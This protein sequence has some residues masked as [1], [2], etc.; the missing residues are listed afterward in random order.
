MDTTMNIRFDKL[1]FVKK[2][3]EANQPPEVAEAFADALDDALDQSQRNLMTKTDFELR[4]TQL[5]AKF[6]TKLS[7][8]EARL[9]D[10][11]NTM[12][13]K[14]VGLMMAGIGFLMTII[15]FIN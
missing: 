9:T 15:K 8:M 14:M 10:T 3:Q 13:Y 5:E 1:R 7:Q 4:L 12:M 2:L 6:D 11:F